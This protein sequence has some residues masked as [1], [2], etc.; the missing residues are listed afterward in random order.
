MLR[1]QSIME[2]ICVI[3][4][5]FVFRHGDWVDGVEDQVDWLIYYLEKKKGEGI[6]F[7]TVLSLLSSVHFQKWSGS[8][9][10]AELRDPQEIL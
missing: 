4:S 6:A 7:S 10:D 3:Y 9:W 2:K 8:P 1:E 5:N